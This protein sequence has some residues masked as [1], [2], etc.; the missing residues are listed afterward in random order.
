MY[1]AEARTNNDVEEWHNRLNSKGRKNMPFYLLLAT[2]H[3]ECLLVDNT[4]DLVRQNT[5]TR[6]QENKYLNLNKKIFQTW[7]EYEEGM[8]DPDELLKKLSQLY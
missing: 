2:L 5:I 4:V 6:R 7:K 1:G 3:E 8:I